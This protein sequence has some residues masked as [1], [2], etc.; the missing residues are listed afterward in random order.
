MIRGEQRKNEDGKMRLRALRGALL[1]GLPMVLTIHV[2]WY[3]TDPHEQQ[4]AGT[5]GLSHEDS[6]YVGDSDSY[7]KQARRLHRD[8]GKSTIAQVIYEGDIFMMNE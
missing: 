2:D 7:I 1:L 6:F 4:R 8:P 5:A 3:W